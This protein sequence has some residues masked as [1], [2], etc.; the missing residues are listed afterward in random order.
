M[1][2]LALDFTTHL[3][4][5]PNPEG[6]LYTSGRDGMIISWDLHLQTRQRPM[7]LPKLQRRWEMLVGRGGGWYGDGEDDTEN[8]PSVG[9]DGDIL[10]DVTVGAGERHRSGVASDREEHWELDPGEFTPGQVCTPLFPCSLEVASWLSLVAFC[11]PTMRAVTLR[12]DK[13]HPVVQ[14]CSDGSVET[15]QFAADPSPVSFQVVSASS[16]GTLKAWNP[17]DIAS[18]PTLVGSHSDYV[19]CL[20]HWYPLRLHVYS[21]SLTMSI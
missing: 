19:R 6:I 9:T 14:P 11:I 13:R 4:D 2:S 1:A 7:K 17:H 12:L 16:D 10:G 8:E 20:A 21:I 15:F 18:D 5:K 3:A